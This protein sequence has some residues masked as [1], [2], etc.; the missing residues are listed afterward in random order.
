[1]SD[2]D[3]KSQPHRRHRIVRR[4]T[5][6]WQRYRLVREVSIVILAIIV[7]GSWGWLVMSVLENPR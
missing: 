4:G 1:M 6:S 7:I 5:D 3:W 2:Q